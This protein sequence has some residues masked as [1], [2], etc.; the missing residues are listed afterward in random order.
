MT[1]KVSTVVKSLEGAWSAIQRKHPEL[2]DVV[3][4]VASGTESG[5]PR[6]GHYAPC[7]W[8]VGEENRHE[9]MV[10]GEGLVRGAPAVLGT[11]LHEAAHA[12]AA[13][14]EV[15]DTS[16]QGRYHNAKFKA[17]A[18]ELGLEIERSDTFGWSTTL[19]PSPCQKSYARPMAAIESALT[20]HR[21]DRSAL[22][23]IPGA[24]RG[25]KGGKGKAGGR[26]DTNFVPAICSCEKPR[27]I[28]LAP[29][30]LEAGAV[31][32]GL[33]ESEFKPKV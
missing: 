32:C 13:V 17:I 23:R 26:K 7:R 2:P 33:C 22:S 3:I 15:D 18:E 28:R 30:T 11:L 6:Y 20:L 1:A 29:S 16:R 25:G 31:V 9:V 4:I 24:S 10:S 27:T 21:N 19:V 5:Q 8:A 14:R 12:I